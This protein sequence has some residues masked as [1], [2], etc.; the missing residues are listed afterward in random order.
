MARRIRP[1]G[2]GE[3][4]RERGPQILE[5]AASLRLS[6]PRSWYF[7]VIASLCRAVSPLAESLRLARQYGFDSGIVLDY[8]YENQPSGFGVL[9]RALDRLALNS[10]GWR[11]SRERLETLKAV[12]R[13][14]IAGNHRAGIKTSVLDLG[15][16]GARYLLEVLSEVPRSEA[17]AVLWDYR[18]ESLA[19]AAQLAASLRVEVCIDSKDAFDDEALLHVTPRPNVIIAAG[20][21]EVTANDSVVRTH[22]HQVFKALDTPGTLIFTVQTQHPQAEL[23]AHILRTHTGRPWMMPL[24]RLDQTLRWA[25]EAG[26]GALVV[27]MSDSAITG[28]V[29]AKKN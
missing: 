22:F 12:L 23:I 13:A 15:C 1:A 26:F 3:S 9:G 27:S 20:L 24:R 2:G 18:R 28:V 6:R 4:F 19:R 11:A 25:T 10:A 16:G 14:A 7:A 8:V 17:S 29:T 5:N 21:H